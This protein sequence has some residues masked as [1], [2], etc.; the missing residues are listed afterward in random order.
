MAA[1]ERV[2]AAIVAGDAPGRRALAALA[3][4]VAGKPPTERE[5]HD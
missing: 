2:I 1:R 5:H 4:D 3:A